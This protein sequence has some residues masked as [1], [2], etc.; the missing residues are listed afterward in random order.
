M[1]KLT[2]TDPDTGVVREVEL[3]DDQARDL[4]AGRPVTW[5]SPEVPDIAVDEDSTLI[6]REDARPKH[7]PNP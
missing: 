7:E 1:A 6:E 5:T 4:L 3:T 2:I